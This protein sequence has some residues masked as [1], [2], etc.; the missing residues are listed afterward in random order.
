MIPSSAPEL[1]T[2]TNW[3]QQL[4]DTMYRAVER[5]LIAD[6]PFGAFLSGGIDSSIIVALMSQVLGTGVK[7]FTVSF[8]EGE[9]DESRFA[10]LVAERYQTEHYE[11]HLSPTD[12]LDM[13]PSALGAM[14]HPSG[15]GPNSYIV[16]K[17]TKEQGISMAL[18]GI[19]GDE[20]FAGYSIFQQSADLN[21]R[22]WLNQVP[23]GIRRVGGRLLQTFRPGISSSKI[24]AV[25][26]QSKVTPARAYPFYRQVFLDEQVGQLLHLSALSPNRVKEQ[27]SQTGQD[28]DFQGLPLMSQIS[29]YE[30]ESYLRNVLLRDTD[31]MSMAHALEVREPFMDRDVVALALRIPDAA[32]SGRHAKQLLVDAFGDLLPA[33]IIYRPKMGFTLPFEEWMRGDLRDFCAQQLVSLGQRPLF[34]AK[35]I[36]RLWQDFLLGK[37]TVS[38]SRVWT[39]VVLG[40]W[41]DKNGL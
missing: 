14:D 13:L 41:L 29:V 35:T 1:E 22:A 19:G 38:W 26:A 36:Q 11:I 5:R 27:V 6:V 15:D 10:A 20:L 7:T 23:G 18:S 24:A 37:K 32:K 39:L 9:Y 17:V 30:S 2:N 8:A 16:S 28:L 25:L 12:F 3:T 21:N 33:E 40:Y 34:V 4:R 31:Q